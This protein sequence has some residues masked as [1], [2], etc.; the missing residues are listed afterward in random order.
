MRSGTISM[1]RKGLT[2]L[3]L[4]GDWD[5][6]KATGNP[7]SSVAVNQYQLMIR[8]EQARAGVTQKSAALLMRDDIIRLLQRMSAWLMDPSLTQDERY[9]MMRD[10]AY[11]AVVF[12]TAK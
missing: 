10:M 7:V 8:E 6:E 2:T 4:V 1:L 5:A 12:A 3:G 11:I 9:E